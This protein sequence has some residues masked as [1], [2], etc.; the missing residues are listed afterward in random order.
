MITGF[1]S[2]VVFGYIKMGNLADGMKYTFI[3]SYDWPSFVLPL[4]F[5]F[6]GVFIAAVIEGAI[7]KA[8]GLAYPVPLSI[9]P[10]AER[11]AD[12]QS[13]RSNYGTF[14]R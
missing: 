6:I 14:E 11:N 7:R 8:C 13:S 12:E 2:I 1:L 9:P 3:D 4:V 5:S 10:Q